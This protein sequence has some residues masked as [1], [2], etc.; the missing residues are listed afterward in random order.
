MDATHGAPVLMGKDR[1]INQPGGVSFFTLTLINPA[2]TEGVSPF[3]GGKPP[4]GC[5]SEG[6]HAPQGGQPPLSPMG[7]KPVGLMRGEVDPAVTPLCLLVE[8]MGRGGAV[9]KGDVSLRYLSDARNL[10][11]TPHVTTGGGR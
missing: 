3:H 10:P 1:A 2:C 6:A 4:P 8:E 5:T 9:P 7:G 11:S